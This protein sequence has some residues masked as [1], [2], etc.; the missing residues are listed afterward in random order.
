MLQLFIPLNFLG[1]VYREIKQSLIDMDKMF[2]LIDIEPSVKDCEGG[3]LSLATGTEFKDVDFYYHK[4]RSILKKLN[5]KIEAGE[6][7]AIVGS[8]GA[9]KST[10][11]RLLMRFYDIQ[12][13]QILIDGQDIREVTQ[14]SF[15]DR[16]V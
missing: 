4:N 7:V 11:S 8:S 12:G 3:I 13:G 1:F 15:E 16:L 6:T 2:E 9:G 14:G 10:I 5:F